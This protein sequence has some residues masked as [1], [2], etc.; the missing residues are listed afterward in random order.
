MRT[1]I[2]HYKQP[3]NYTLIQA[4]KWSQNNQSV[5][6][7]FDL[8]SVVKNKGVYTIVVYLP[9]VLYIDGHNNPA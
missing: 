4:D 2:F 7:G 1:S 6:V 8:S 9:R 5:D 3:S